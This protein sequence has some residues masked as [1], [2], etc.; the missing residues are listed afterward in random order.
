LVKINLPIS[1][2]GESR[3]HCIVMGGLETRGKK[4]DDVN[5]SNLTLRDSKVDGVCGCDGASIH[6][7][8]VSVENS[9]RFGVYVYGT[10]RST[11]KNCNVSHSKESGLSVWNG[12]L[13]TIEGNGTTIHHNCTNGDSDDYGLHTDDSSSSI[14]LA[15]SLTI[16]TISKNNGG[17]GNH[18]GWG[19]IKTMTNNKKEA[20]Q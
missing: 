5:V 10:K 18:G 4:E 15:S 9:G 3:E 11:M 6:L 12:G 17:G 19:T 8:N 16:E 2:I 1:I 7:D 14:H 20:K 13:M